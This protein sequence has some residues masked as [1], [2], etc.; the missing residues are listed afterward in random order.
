MISIS[1]NLLIISNRRVS[2]SLSRLNPLLNVFTV[3]AIW[4]LTVNPLPNPVIASTTKP[5]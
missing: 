1:I 2:F 3:R 5:G 4:N